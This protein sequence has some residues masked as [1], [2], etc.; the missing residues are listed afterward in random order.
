MTR[1]LAGFI[2]GAGCAL[3]LMSIG[4]EKVALVPAQETA[5]KAA[6]AQKP[7][8]HVSPVFEGLVGRDPDGVRQEPTLSSRVSVYLTKGRGAGIAGV[9]YRKQSAIELRDRGLN[10]VAHEVSHFVDRTLWDRDIDDDETEAYLQGF[11]TDC[12]WDLIKGR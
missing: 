1:Y 4:R 10:T 8:D 3:A 12:V 9:F 11:Y 2:F 6:E 7:D 5:P